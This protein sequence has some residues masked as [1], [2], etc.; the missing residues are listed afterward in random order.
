MSKFKSAITRIK[1]PAETIY[2]FLSDFNNFKNIMPADKVKNYQSTLDTCSFSVENMP[3][4]HLKMGD[5]IRASKIVMIPQNSGGIEFSLSTS[6]E[7]VSQ[8]DSEVIITLSAEL[9]AFLK[10]MAA[11]PLQTF[12]DTLA[13]KLKEYMER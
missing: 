12:V 10:M 6:I 2:D 3:A 13:V 4:F 9:N 1:R 11:K 7:Q 8:S 5:N